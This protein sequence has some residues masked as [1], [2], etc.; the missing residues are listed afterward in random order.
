MPATERR[1]SIVVG[2]G[3]AGCTAALYAKRYNLDVLLL[4]KTAPGGQTATA[5]GIENYP[6]FPDGISGPELAERIHQQ[7]ENH[8]VPLQLAEV[9]GLEAHGDDWLL[10][11]TQGDYVAATIIIA[12][13]AHPRSLEV[14]GEEELR[15]AGV[16]YCATCDGFF[17]KGETV[18]VVGGGDAAIEEALYLSQ[19]AAQVY[20][21]HRRDELR[22]QPYLQQQAF[23]Q[24]NIQLIWDSVVTRIIG[25]GQVQALELHN[26]LSGEDS[27]LELQGVFVAI[28]YVPATG[29][30]GELLEL[31][32]G[33]VVTDQLMWT[34]Q[35]GIFAAGDV[36]DTPVRQI[37]TAVGDATIA[38]YSAY[39]YII[40][41]Q[42]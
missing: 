29:W 36:R 11:T 10:H 30:L 33:F 8:G 20:L 25:D 1:D 3:V 16:S 38:A 5:S 2:G 34:N 17:F 35:A 42:G 4:E 15:G 18:A 21:I 39:R 22:A 19:L 9:T 12:A 41:R 32:D 6:G 7:A 13:G 24:P 40:Q 27:R 37:T 23:A 26:K 31:R 28:G 14:P